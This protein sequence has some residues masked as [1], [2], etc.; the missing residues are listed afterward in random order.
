M[1]TIEDA[2]DKII[3]K[4]PE[5]NFEL[6]EFNGSIGKCKI[7]C[8]KCGEINEKK[9]FTSFLQNKNFCNNCKSVNYNKKIDDILISQNL[10][11]VKHF[12][13]K[14]EDGRG[15]KHYVTIHCNTCNNTWDRISDDIITGKSKGC[16]YCGQHKNYKE[17][18][19]EQL[20]E[21]GDESF[22]LVSKFDS[23]AKHVLIRHED[24]GFIFRIKPQSIVSNKKIS[25]PKCKRLES[26]GEEK[27]R[28]YLENNNIEFDSQVRY[29]ELGRLSFDFRVVQE[30]QVILIEFQG[31][32]H[33]RPVKC[34]GGIEHFF[35][36]QKYDEEKRQFCLNNNYTL[37]E[38]PYRD[39]N[40]ID[41]YLNFLV[42]RLQ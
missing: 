6:L 26:K 1:L 24:C 41:S 35:K 5:A 31:D 2:K 14:R 9:N 38:I 34:F 8:L 28:K 33:Y 12:M 22:S 16:L 19:E 37:I 10:I 29:P 18:F 13:I 36:Q 42:Q 23:N 25:C 3:Q 30:K 4:W 11:P 32:Q 20:K 7:K 27:I 17:K 21:Y 15:S 40:K 39:M